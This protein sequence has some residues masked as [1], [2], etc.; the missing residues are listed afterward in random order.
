[1]QKFIPVEMQAMGVN[2]WYGAILALGFT[3][4][5]SYRLVRWIAGFATLLFSY[6]LLK[7]LVY[8][9][10]LG[11]SVRISSLTRLEMLFLGLYVLTNALCM[12]L[13][14]KS[15]TDAATRSGVLSVINLVPLFAGSR[16]GLLADLLGVSLRSQL[17]LHR[18]MGML[19]TV[20]GILHSA[21]A[22]FGPT[23]G[24]WDGFRIF[25]AVVSVGHL[26]CRS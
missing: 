3:L 22:I 19:A 26:Q 17:L 13:G 20:Q 6:F 23:R 24:P 12:G 16:L 5:I 7:H 15:T 9:N 14:V 8:P 1:M 25:G 10:T 18:Y 11:S 21:V 2:F 4:W